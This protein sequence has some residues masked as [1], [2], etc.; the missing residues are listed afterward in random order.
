MNARCVVCDA[1]IRWTRSRTYCSRHYWR[2]RR[3][4]DKPRFELEQIAV[5]ADH[6]KT[7]IGIVLDDE[8]SQIDV[9][10]PQRR[11]ALRSGREE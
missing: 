7:L 5:E 3:L 8:R 1:P 11:D 2:L 10:E 9:A 4:A 6:T